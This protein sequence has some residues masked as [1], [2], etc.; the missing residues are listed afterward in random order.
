M[1]PKKKKRKNVVTAT[2][3]AADAAAAPPS[4]RYRAVLWGSWKP[5]PG[6]Q[7]FLHCPGLRHF[8][9]Q[10]CYCTPLA[11]V[12]GAIHCSS[13]QAANCY[14]T[15]L[16]LVGGAIYCRCCRVAGLPSGRWSGRSGSVQ[17]FL[18]TTPSI[19]Q[20]TNTATT[21]SSI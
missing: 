21:P 16:A 1:P 20:T 6:Q 17:S 19:R 10:L 4:Y 13:S 3:A 9:S 18:T 14:Y 12:G 8:D 15:P 7:V 11:L 2:A 5:P